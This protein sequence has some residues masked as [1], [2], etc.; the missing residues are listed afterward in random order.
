[1]PL[2]A[3]ARRCT[4]LRPATP[5][6]Q[7]QSLWWSLVQYSY[8]LQAHTAHFPRRG[9]FCVAGPPAAH[10]PPTKHICRLAI[11][12]YTQLHVRPQGCDM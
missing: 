8:R 3:A 5:S 9:I 7:L 1:M 4:Q 12:S 2:R 6:Y 11:T 10:A